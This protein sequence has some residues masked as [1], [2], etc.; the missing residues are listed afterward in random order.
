MHTDGNPIRGALLR[1][2]T[3]DV[4]TAH[5]AFT[6][7][8]FLDLAARRPCVVLTLGDV[9]SGEPLLARIHSSC[10][11]SESLGGCDCDCAGRPARD[12]HSLRSIVRGSQ[13]RVGR[14]FER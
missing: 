13:G 8:V 11:T 5:G 3:R 7:H 12:R 1:R 14:D 6:A 9:R 4:Q 2:E 10:V